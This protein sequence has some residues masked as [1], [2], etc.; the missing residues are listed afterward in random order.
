MN[1]IHGT[2]SVAL[3]LLNIYYLLVDHIHLIWVNMNKHLHDFQQ[4]SDLKK[5]GLTRE[6]WL[7]YFAFNWIYMAYGML[8]W[9]LGVATWFKGFDW[10]YQRMHILSSMLFYQSA[11]VLLDLQRYRYSALLDVNKWSWNVQCIYV[12]AV[13]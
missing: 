7:L 6:H 8:F 5:A 4:S 11:G 10:F 13:L 3:M 9:I 12:A 2:V 1:E